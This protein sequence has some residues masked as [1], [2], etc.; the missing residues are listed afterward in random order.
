MHYRSFSF[1]R[2]INIFIFVIL[3][4]IHFRVKVNRI[5]YNTILKSL[6]GSRMNG[7][8]DKDFLSKYNKFYKASS[9]LL[10]WLLKDPNPCMIRSLILHELCTM[11]KVNSVLKTGVKKNNQLLDGH[12][13]VEI[14]GEPINEKRQYLKGFTVI[15]ET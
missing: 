11:N 13:W 12:S 15:H 3:K 6:E 8:A 14:D 10:I 7:K 5:G 9:F 4:I 1:P 2:D